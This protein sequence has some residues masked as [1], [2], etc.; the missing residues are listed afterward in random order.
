MLQGIA[1]L[2]LDA[3]RFQRQEGG[4]LFWGHLAVPVVVVVLRGVLH[5]LRGTIVATVV[6]RVV[7]VVIAALDAPRIVLR[8]ELV[9]REVR[10]VLLAGVGNR[11]SVLV[12]VP[13]VIVVHGLAQRLPLQRIERWALVLCALD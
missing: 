6:G 9:H 2:V 7:A 13:I 4:V 3:L 12:L 5:R 10:G 1:I 11:V 8:Q